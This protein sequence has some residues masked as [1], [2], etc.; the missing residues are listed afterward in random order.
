MSR[1]YQKERLFENTF[2]KLRMPFDYLYFGTYYR[3][4]ASI[5]GTPSAVLAKDWNYII[6]H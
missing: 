3:H 5:I 2:I 1:L 4:L 6:F